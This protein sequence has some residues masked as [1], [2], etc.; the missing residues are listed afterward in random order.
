MVN[1]G[2]KASKKQRGRYLKNSTPKNQINNWQKFIKFLSLLSSFLCFFWLIFVFYSYPLLNNNF[3]LFEFTALLFL[4]LYYFIVS[5][6]KLSLFEKFLYN[7]FYLFVSIFLLSAFVFINKTIDNEVYNFEKRYH[8]CG[9]V[10]LFEIV[11]HYHR[12]HYS[13]SY[14][15]SI[16]GIN[17]VFRHN[18]DFLLPKE[19]DNICITY[20]YNKKWINDGYKII[21]MQYHE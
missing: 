16:D 1:V 5:F 4:I 11:P 20:I 6:F 21:D 14:F 9:K 10:L 12:G 17:F 2:R 19:N 8:H 7:G 15:F 3:A 18:S 13:Y